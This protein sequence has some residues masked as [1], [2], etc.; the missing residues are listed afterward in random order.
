MLRYLG[1]IE[2]ND[3]LNKDCQWFKAL[4][5]SC[6]ISAEPAWKFT[7]TEKTILGAIDKK[8]KY[9]ARDQDGS[10]YLYY[11]ASIKRDDCWEQDYDF[12]DLMD[13]QGMFQT[14]KWEDDEPCE[15]RRYFFYEQRC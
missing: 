4:C 14:I 13:F 1:N 11:E 8:Y 10:I 9:I 2:E 7:D 6:G 12:S 3:T 5:K 15:F